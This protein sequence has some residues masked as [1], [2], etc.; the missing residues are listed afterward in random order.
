MTTSEELENDNW[1]RGLWRMT[2]AVEMAEF[3]SS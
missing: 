2:T 3:V 1:T